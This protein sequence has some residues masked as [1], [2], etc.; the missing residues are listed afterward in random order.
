MKLIYSKKKKRNKKK[1]NKKNKFCDQ[2]Q[3]TRF[4]DPRA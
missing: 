4:L 2:N 3:S 1:T